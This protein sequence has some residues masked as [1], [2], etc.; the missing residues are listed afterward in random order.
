VEILSRKHHEELFSG[1]GLILPTE[2]TVD[3]MRETLR[4]QGKESLYFFSTAILNWNKI[5]KQ[6]HFELCN[7]IQNI[8]PPH[9][10]R[11]VLLVPR[12]T[13]KSTVGSKSLPL[14][15]ILQDEFCGLPGREHRI[16]LWS[17]SGD[18]AKKQIKSMRQQVERN[19][20]LHWLYPEI[21]PD[22]Q[23]TTW[24]DSNLL[25]PR[26]GSYGEDT[27]ESAG[28]DTHLVSRHYTVQI[29]DDLEDK[30][31]YESPTIRQKVKDSYKSAESLFV[32]E[33]QAYD[34]LIGTRWGHD[35]VYAD[36]QRDESD[37]YE[38]MVRPLH[39]TRTELETDLEEARKDKVPPVWNMEP[40]KYAPEYG[41]T[42]YFFEELFP[43][44]SCKRIRQ[45]QGTF[46]YSML[47]LN[48]PKNPELS[49][50]NENDLRYFVFDDEGNL[51]LDRDDGTHEVV[52][53]AGL[54]RVLFWDPAMSEAE[55]KKNARN[56]MIVMFK[57]VKGRLF[58]P[59]AFI[60]RKNPTLLFSKFISLH[61]RYEIQHAAIED[62]G[63]QRT[64]KFP[65]FYEMRQVN[66]TFSV[67]EQAPIASK[68][69]RIRTLAPFVENHMLYVRRGGLGV[70]EFVDE[71]KTFPLTATV[72]A[73][74]A[75]A[76]C[77]PLLGMVHSEQ[78]QR[79]MY[80]LRKASGLEE[81]R[82]ATR[83]EVTG[84]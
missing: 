40:D 61:Q 7:F 67:L 35:D 39:W 65:L 71:L 72:D 50:F 81:S 14:W 53:F 23:R 68:H 8:A 36:I 15:I 25:F 83:S 56:A 38:F 3:E 58:L 78:G 43:A 22:F 60:E 59:E 4:R 74:D 33:Q 64:L 76:A 19:Q 57:D 70:K 63:F 17:H 82:L 30:A 47:Y 18:N 1:T 55:Q 16:L 26:E 80:R 75:G 31:S 28:I 79:D 20:L 24:T 45:K 66:Y 77:L 10:R 62:V 52:P 42:Y 5:R 37:T 69:A 41:K 51:V 21:I 34:L 73:L 11:K 13:Y 6:P 2:S 9:G 12:D 46:M 29:K 54:R 48:N 32:D 49:E 84:Y 27:I 44:A